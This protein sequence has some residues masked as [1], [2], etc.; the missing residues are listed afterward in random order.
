MLQDKKRASIVFT[1]LP[2]VYVALSYNLFY[3]VS[4]SLLPN[5]LSLGASIVEQL[6]LSYFY[7]T[8]WLFL[9]VSGAVPTGA[10][11]LTA[12]AELRP[13]WLGRRFR[14]DRSVLKNE[15]GLVT[16]PVEGGNT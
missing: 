11:A 1:A 15:K 12:I 3:F 2:L 9:L 6:K 7:Q 14:M 4:P 5:Y 13:G 8:Q 10:Y 16:Q